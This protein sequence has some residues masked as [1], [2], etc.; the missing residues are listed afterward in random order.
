MNIFLALFECGNAVTAQPMSRAACM[1]LS[2][3][4][5]SLTS[6]GYTCRHALAP[7][8]SIVCRDPKNRRSRASI[9]ASSSPWHSHC[10]ADIETTPSKHRSLNGSPCPKSPLSTAPVAAPSP[11]SN[12]AWLASTPTDT[13]PRAL[14]TSEESPDPHPM[15]AMS[16]GPTRSAGCSTS[17]S[18]AHSVS[19]RWT[20]SFCEVYRAASSR[21]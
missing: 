7:G 8:R 6:R 3:L 19:S 9:A 11:V 2:I 1:A 16:S 4:R 14:M 15:S 10:A 17:R 12:I 20:L 21:S 18:S 13:C 5:V